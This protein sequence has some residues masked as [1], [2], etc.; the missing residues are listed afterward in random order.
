[1]G[2]VKDVRYIHCYWPKLDR[3]TR[4]FAEGSSGVRVLGRTPRNVWF[5][6]DVVFEDYYPDA[7][8]HAGQAVGRPLVNLTN[9][10]A[11]SWL[12]AYEKAVSQLPPTAAVHATQRNTNFLRHRQIVSAADAKPRYEEYVA[13]LS[14]QEAVDL[15]DGKVA[16]QTLRGTKQFVSLDDQAKRRTLAEFAAASVAGSEAIDVR[17]TD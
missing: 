5:P 14:P 4:I 9:E 3:P 12:A 11:A 8:H 2:I 16:E 1:M 15:V 17:A 6:D 13:E 10:E 7:E